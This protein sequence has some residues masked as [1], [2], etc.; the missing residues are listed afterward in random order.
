MK[1]KLLK[2]LMIICMSFGLAVTSVPASVLAAG[3]S[4]IETYSEDV[5]EAHQSS[6][7]TEAETKKHKETEK[8]T[9]H[10]SETEVQSGFVPD[11]E[12]PVQIEASVQEA[13]V[14]EVTPETQAAAGKAVRSTN[15]PVQV[16][17]QDKDYIKEGNNYTIKEDC[18]VTMVLKD[19]I[20]IGDIVV[21]NNAVLKLYLKGKKENSIAN[22][23][24]AGEVIFCKT[25]NDIVCNGKVSLKGSI[26]VA[27]LTVEGGTLFGNGRV[28]SSEVVVKGGSLA[29]NILDTIK[30]TSSSGKELKKTVF[31][32]DKNA[33]CTISG[34]ED[35]VVWS[36][37]EGNVVLYLASDSLAAIQI[38]AV[39]FNVS[40]NEDSITV[41]KQA[42]T[43]EDK[44]I[45]KG[46]STTA[47]TV[48]AGADL[49][50]V[51]GEKLENVD[52]ITVTGTKDYIPGVSLEYD[53]SMDAT[54]EL[55]D[56]TT[57][58]YKVTKTDVK[59]IPGEYS[60]SLSQVTVTD[61][62]GFEH[63]LTG[64]VNLKI[65]K[66]ELTPTI[67]V[68]KTST[69]SKSKATKVYDGTTD[70]PED[71]CELTGFTDVVSGD[72]A[73]DILAAA[74]ATF[75][76]DHADVATA[77]KI[78]ATVTLKGDWGKK[79]TVASVEKSAEITKARCPD[80][81]TKKLVK[82]TLEERHYEWFSYKTT[83]G[84]EY[85]YS[86]K[87]KDDEWKLSKNAEI[88]TYINEVDGEEVALK[89]GTSYKVYTR[90][91][92][93]DNYLA[94]DPVSV[95]FKTLR[96][97]KEAKESDVKLTGVTDNSTQKL[98][99]TLEFTATGSTYVDDKDYEP[100]LDDE[101]Y[102]P[103]SW[104]LTD[105]TTWKNQKST[106]KFTVKP[107]Q[108]GTYTI[109]A[110]FR[111]YVYN[112]E[113]WERDEDG[114]VKK[115]LTFKAN[116][117]GISSTSSTNKSGSTSTVKS[118]TTAAKT[119]DTTPLIPIAAAF[120]LSGAVIAAVTKKRKRCN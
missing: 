98:D 81:L 18:E 64:T 59:E 6:A 83:A 19:G 75:V 67:T 89:S 42:Y 34:A 62:L 5:T 61:T 49:E 112:G 101:K 72:K 114:D 88:I 43:Y 37:T 78:T 93:S 77:K 17:E 27:K 8:E 97:P 20:S 71:T 35:N 21:E 22:I 69:S 24:G 30:V 32:V 57:K 102:V 51:Y 12:I 25:N 100:S 107:T 90:I 119:G 95:S 58:G 53:E 116:S 113:E 118:T 86:E 105:T 10:H 76:Y 13:P 66:K 117:T 79:Y 4:T 56:A 39:S 16:G 54:L 31:K 28:E 70:V 109:V 46:K 23:S 68:N 110:T 106:Q 74:T 47:Y 41:K 65:E 120:V 50:T 73:S 9:K 40:E 60:Y 80:E 2:K 3:D 99:T 87:A 48:Q 84:Q 82:P 85:A 15:N 108:A 38:D 33:F 96:A 45:K 104:K 103:Y 55:K 44:S 111:K 7:E 29:C 92:E 36:D 52:I 91:P 1:L 115:S 11:T 94:S 14:Q 26:S 63:E